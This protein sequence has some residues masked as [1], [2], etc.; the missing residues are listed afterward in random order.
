MTSYDAYLIAGFF[1]CSYDSYGLAL[2]CFG[3]AI[4][5]AYVEWKR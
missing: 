4:L 2:A 1:L 3:L 5:C